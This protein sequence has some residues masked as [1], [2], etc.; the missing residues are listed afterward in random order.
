MSWIETTL[1]PNAEHAAIYTV[2]AGLVTTLILA[3]FRRILRKI[4][5]AI[6]SLDPMTDTGVTR[7]L[8]KLQDDISDSL[9][10]KHHGRPIR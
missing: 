5:R 10:V 1:L 2:T 8:N 7:E 4:W 3:P 6:D 9:G